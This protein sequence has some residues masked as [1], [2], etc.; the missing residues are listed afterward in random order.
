[1]LW[2]ECDY[3][4]VVGCSCGDRERSFP[5]LHLSLEDNCVNPILVS[6]RS[7]LIT[8]LLIVMTG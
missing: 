4:A 1:M 3:V 7:A 8:S 6:Q 2:S 5:N